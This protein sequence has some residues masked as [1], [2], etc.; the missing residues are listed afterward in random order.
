MKYPMLPSPHQHGDYPEPPEGYGLIATAADRDAAGPKQV[1]DMVWLE[2][3]ET[4]TRMQ[5]PRLPFRDTLIYA[6]KLK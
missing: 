4:W 2:S 3:E 6:R 5:N 1:G